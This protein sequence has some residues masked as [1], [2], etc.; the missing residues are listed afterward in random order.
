MCGRGLGSSVRGTQVSVL[1]LTLPGCVK[2]VFFL[3]IVLLTLFLI[4]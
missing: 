1:V 3:I 4:L 2:L